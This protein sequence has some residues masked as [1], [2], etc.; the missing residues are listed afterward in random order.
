M[1]ISICSEGVPFFH[2]KRCFQRI[3]L[4][5]IIQSGY[6]ASLMLLYFNRENLDRSFKNRHNVKDMEHKR[7]NIVV[8][9]LCRKSQRDP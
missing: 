5:I 9:S 6:L 1:D 3:R 4:A 7:Q 8:K 2:S